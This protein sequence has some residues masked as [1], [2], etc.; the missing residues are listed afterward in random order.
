MKSRT[1]NM[2]A[3]LVLMVA[4]VLTATSLWTPVLGAT[5]PQSQSIE[6]SESHGG[7]LEGTWRMQVT[8]RDCASGAALRTFPAFPTFAQGGTLT[9]TTTGFPPVLR[10]PGHGVWEHLGGQT[11][12]AV[13]E[14]FLFNPAGAWTG[15]QRL[16][17]IIE[18][19][20]DG[21]EMNSNATNEIFDTNGNL[22]VNG[23]ATAVGTYFE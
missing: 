2:V 17:Q 19:S 5:G 16:T 1:M 11:Y 21:E 3:G 4:L 6:D 14:A 13:S 20:N 7:K 12:R 8:I 23:C 9:E 10:T 18:V 22:I 15:R